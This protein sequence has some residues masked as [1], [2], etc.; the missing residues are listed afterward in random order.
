[1]N[2]ERRFVLRTLAQFA[3]ALPLGGRGLAAADGWRCS[4][5]S[6]RRGASSRP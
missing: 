1:M 4:R 6:R 5:C 3:V 2:V